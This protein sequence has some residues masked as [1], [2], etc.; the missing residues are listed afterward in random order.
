MHLW[1]CFRF[2]VGTYDGCDLW[3]I[4]LR[5]LSWDRVQFGGFQCLHML[6]TLSLRAA[7]VLQLRSPALIPASYF[8]LQPMQL[9]HVQNP[10][11][12]NSDVSLMTISV[13][14][15]ASVPVVRV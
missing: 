14:A 15:A 10:R 2:H 13:A 4:V 3:L 5:C 9:L 8:A 12:Q 11:N 7:H 1:L 6:S